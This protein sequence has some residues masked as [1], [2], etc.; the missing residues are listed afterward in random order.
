MEWETTSPPPVYNFL[1]IPTVV[2]GP[3]EYSDPVA[4][5]LLGRDWLSQTEPYPTEE[6]TAANAAPA[7]ENA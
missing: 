4:T 7:E 1:E 3:H 6:S 5:K 2:R